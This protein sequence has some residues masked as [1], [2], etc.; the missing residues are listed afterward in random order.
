MIPVLLVTDD[1]FFG[2]L[3]GKTAEGRISR[4]KTD[5]DAPTS[6]TSPNL[7]YRLLIP[8]TDTSPDLAS[9]TLTSERMSGA[10]RWRTARA[11]YCPRGA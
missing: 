4:H 7:P 9:I 2:V 8:F 1:E 3:A 6:P 5:V 11:M 10:D